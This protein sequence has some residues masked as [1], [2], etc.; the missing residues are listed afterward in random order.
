MKR[1]NTADVRRARQALRAVLVSGI[2]F[3]GFNTWLVV[4]GDWPPF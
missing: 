2:L 1:P 4:R 3:L